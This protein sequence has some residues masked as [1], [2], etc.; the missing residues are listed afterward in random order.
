MQYYWHSLD[1]E[2][3]HVTMRQAGGG[4]NGVGAF[5]WDGTLFLEFIDNTMDAKD[6]MKLMK[7]Q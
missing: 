2:P 4:D 6:Y 7:K 5:G 1:K 3:E